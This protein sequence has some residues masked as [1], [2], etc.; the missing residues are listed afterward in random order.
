M[1]WQHAKG[2]QTAGIAMAKQY[3]VCTGRRQ[4]TT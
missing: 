4:G 2:P 3:G 1:A